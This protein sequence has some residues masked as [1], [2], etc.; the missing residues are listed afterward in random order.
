MRSK[1]AGSR[2]RRSLAD[3]PKRKKRTMKELRKMPRA[4]GSGPMMT[5]PYHAVLIAAI[6]NAWAS[7][8][9]VHSEL[10]EYLVSEPH[11]TATAT[12]RDKIGPMIFGMMQTFSQ[13][14]EL[15]IV[16][17]KARFTDDE[18]KTFLPRLDEIKA[19]LYTASRARNR[20]AHS[21]WGGD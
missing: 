15:T 17:I 9:A 4:F 1:V 11:L 10:I 6:T 18:Y 3:K 13:R 5:R 14:W 19:L 2:T 21:L 16:A 7:I 12:A 20:T 8:E